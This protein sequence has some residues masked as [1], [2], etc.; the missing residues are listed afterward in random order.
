MTVEGFS[1][2]AKTTVCR[3]LLV[4]VAVLLAAA[5][6]SR[7]PPK[8]EQQGETI[9]R[10][11][12][13]GRIE[14]FF[15]YERLRAGKPSRFLIHLTDLTDG[16]PVEKA[17]VTLTVRPAGGGAPVSETK[18]RA[19]KVAGIY[20]AEITAPSPGRYDLEFHLRNDKIEERMPLQ[21]FNAE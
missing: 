19:G 13:T 1:R 11:E 12:F 7:Q 6:D 17:D 14:N 20:V 10:T 9:A 3:W 15:E 18:A 5:C 4:S 2:L 16:S 8:A 21:E